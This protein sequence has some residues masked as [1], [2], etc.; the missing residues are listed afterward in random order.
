M[1]LALAISPVVHGA[2][3]A[4][5]G[6]KVWDSL[7]P[8]GQASSIATSRDGSKVFVTG[9]VVEG[10]NRDYATVAY[11]AAT[12]VQLWATRYDG[13]AHGVDEG[14]AIAVSPDGTKVFVTGNSERDT[15]S[16]ITS[17]Y[18]TLAY[19]SV[20]GR[21]LW[22]SLNTA[23]PGGRAEATSIGVNADGSL[24]F[25]TGSMDR[26]LRGDRDYQTVAYATSNGGR[27]WSARYNGPARGDDLAKAMTVNATGTKVFVT[28]SSDGG[29]ATGLDYATLAYDA[30]SG[31]QLWVA[32][33]D[34]SRGGSDAAR[35]IAFNANGHKLVVTGSSGWTVAYNPD[36]AATRWVAHHDARM[37]SVV[38]SPGG[39]AVY[40]AGTTGS[41]YETVALSAADGS[42]R[43]ERMWDP[44]DGNSA[45]AR[46]IGI[47]PDGSKVFVT[48]LVAL[49]VHG[50]VYGTV[51]YGTAA[52]TELWTA[53]YGNSD[54]F[55]G[56]DA[57]A[58]AVS[59]DGSKV[60]VTGAAFVGFGAS[61]EYDYGTVAY[62]T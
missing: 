22:V 14:T 60:F 38:I 24:V 49:A 8:S 37:S 48:G 56:S 62:Q 52:G 30:R 2:T 36:T 61:F 31:A 57:R 54:I 39:T 44:F 42:E 5:P 1:I 23:P 10:S 7:Y 41:A 18:A 50:Y 15:G 55:L 35:S 45:D 28:G 51:A 59:S 20:T 25:V 46:A 47:S 17:D 21:Q 40:T 9:F 12:G 3:G 13:P 27:I 6:T 33:L 43:W 34:G 32:R 19:D 53:T 4:G 16:G 26:G 11:D 29:P 58:L